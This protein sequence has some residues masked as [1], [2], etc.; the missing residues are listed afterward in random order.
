MTLTETVLIKLGT[1]LSK[2]LLKRYLGD[3]AE[4]IG[5][6][7]I[8]VAKGKIESYMDRQEAKRQFERIGERIASQLLPFFESETLP[9]EVSVEAVVDQLAGALEGNISAEFFLARD[10]DPGKLIA[11]L[12]RAHPLPKAQF[13]EA[14]EELYDRALA[15]AVRYVVEIAAKLPRFEV[16][17][18]KESLQRLARME[19][20]VGETAKSVKN[21]ERW[22]ASQESDAA[23]RQYEVDYR[24]AVSR[25]LDYL[26]LFGADLMPES[27]RQSL[28]VA[29]VSLTL[30]SAS[31][32][33]SEE[34]EPSPVE[35][36]LG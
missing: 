3:P 29:Y 15:E 17:Q 8:D 21:I 20:I 12:R 27:R 35:A 4:S 28:S 23:S 9:Q 18:V 16:T 13:S 34:A 14:E 10:L 1:R 31:T 33:G 6:D 2:M 7:L 25:N 11:E 22:V 32:S 5:A 24:L 26:E 19:D 36:V 30:E